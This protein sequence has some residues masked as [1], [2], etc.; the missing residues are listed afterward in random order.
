MFYRKKDR[1]SIRKFKVGV[2]SVFLG[3]FLL[4]TPQ[5]YADDAV[6][7][8]AETEVVSSTMEDTDKPVA[9]ESPVLSKDS[10][11]VFLTPAM[12]DD[13]IVKVAEVSS[14]DGATTDVVAS[15]SEESVS[16][17]ASVSTVTS[18]KKTETRP[19]GSST[20]VKSEVP[21][22][23]SSTE[24]QNKEEVNGLSVSQV[25]PDSSV[26]DSDTKEQASPEVSAPKDMLTVARTQTPEEITASA[27]PSSELKASYDRLNEATDAAALELM[28]KKARRAQ[29]RSTTFPNEGKAI[30]TGAGFRADVAASLLTEPS[31]I[32]RPANTVLDKDGFDVLKRFSNKPGIVYV[33]NAGTRTT[34]DKNITEKQKSVTI[35]EVDTNTGKMTPVSTSVLDDGTQVLDHIAK[36]RDEQKIKPGDN[37]NP[38]YVQMNGLGLSQDGRYAY[39]FGFTSNINEEDRTT[40]NGIYRY[41][42]QSK[43]WSLVSNASNWDANFA[44]LKTNSWTAGA[45]NPA[46]GKY[47]FGTYTRQYDP[48]F[49]TVQF[50]N[51]NDFTSKVTTVRDAISKD[52]SLTDEQKRDM[53]AESIKKGGFEFYFRLFSYD[54]V[55]HKV[56]DVGYTSTHIVETGSFDWTQTYWSSLALGNDIVF[57]AEGN[58]KIT[59]NQ[60]GK[61]EFQVL[62]ISKDEIAKGVAANNK[63]TNLNSTLSKKIAITLADGNALPADAWAMG[64]AALDNNGNFYL[65]DSLNVIKSYSDFSGTTL[66]FTRKDDDKSLS[67]WGDAASIFGSVGTGSVRREYYIENT[68]TILEGQVGTIVNGKFVSQDK[69]TTGKENIAEKLEYYKVY[70]S[71]N[72]PQ[73]IQAKNGDVYILVKNQEGNATLKYGSDLETGQVTKDEQVIKYQYKKLTGDVILHYVDTDGHVLQPNHHLKDDVPVG[74]KYEVTKGT[75]DYPNTIEKDDIVYK[76]KEISADGIVNKVKVATENVTLEQTGDV[77]AGKKNIVY[78]YEPTGSVVIHYVNTKGE[79][80]KKEVQDNV[81]NATIGTAYNAT[82]NGEK[83]E[84]ITHGGKTYKIKETN[85]TG[86]VGT[87]AIVTPN[88]TNF[89]GEEMSTIQTPGKTHVIYVYEEVPTEPSTPDKQAA[90]I[91]YYD[92]TTGEKVQL[93][94]VDKE[95]GV[96]GGKA[97]YTTTKRIKEYED[98]GYELVND[99]VPIPIIFDNEKDASEADPTQK[100][101]VLLSHA[102]V[103]VDPAS[104]KDPNEPI[105]PKDPS[106]PKWP[107][108]EEAQVKRTATRTIRYRYADKPGLDQEAVFEDVV[109]TVEFKRAANV[110]KVT[111]KVVSYG[112]WEAVVAEIPEKASPTKEGYIF[113]KDAPKETATISEDGTISGIHDQLILYKKN[114]VKTGSVVVKYEDTEGHKIAEDE[115]DTPE[116]PVGTKY[117]TYDQIEEII[118][119]DD[120]DVY[121]LKELKKGSANE[122]GEVVEGVT[123]VTYVYE[124]AGF[125]EVKYVDETGTEIKATVGAVKYAKPGSNY[126]TTT[127]TLRPTK[128]TTQD[129]KVYELVSEG[130]YTVGS[131]DSVGH[132]TSTD[133]VDG[134]VEAGKTKS[135]TY[136]YKEVKNDVPTPPKAANTGSVVVHYVNTEGEVIH[137]D[138]KDT[139]DAPVGTE[140]NAAET[141]LEKPDYIRF[142]GKTYKYK[143]FTNSNHVNNKVIVP[144]SDYDFIGPEKSTVSSGTTHVIYV[145]EEVKED[146]PTIPEPIKT[147]AV[148]VRYV[149][150]NGE[151]IKD[152]VF[153]EKNQPEGIAYDTTDDNRPT[154]VLGKDGQIYEIVGAGEQNVGMV[155]HHGRLTAPAGGQFWKPSDPETGLVE[156]D[157]IKEITY[158]YKLKEVPKA[159]IKKGSVIVRYEDTEGNEINTPAQDTIDAP[160]GTPY[161]TFDNRLEVIHSDNTA[162][163]A[164][165]V[166]YLKEVKSNSASETGIVTEGTTTVT[167]V[168]EKGG[169]V[170]VNY[171]DEN[172][173]EIQQTKRVLSDAKPGSYYNVTTTNIRP[174]QI[175]TEDGKIYE[176]V[177]AGEYAVGK[178]DSIG[179]LTTT[180]AVESH[181]EANKLKSVTYVYKLKESTITPPAEAP[182]TGTVLVHYVNTNGDEIH[183]KYY[184]T[185]NAPIGTEYNTA[186]S[187]VEK[188]KFINFE[189]KTYKYKGTEETTNIINGKVIVPNTLQDYIRSEKSTVLSGTV[190]VIYVYEEVKE[191]VPPTPDTKLGSVVVRYVDENGKE[192]KDEVPDTMDAPEGTRYETYDKKENIITTKEGDVY[193]FKTVDEQSAPEAGNVKEGTTTVTYVYEKAGNVVVNYKDKEGNAIQDPVKDEE[194]SKPGTPYD[195]MDNRPEEIK[196]KDGKTYKRVP[197]LTEGEETGKVVSG[198]TEVTYVYEEVKGK[199]VVHYI[200]L[201]GKTIKDDVVDTPETSTGV[202]YDTKDHKPATITKDG[203]EYELLPALTQGQETGKVVSGTTEVTYVYRLK[204]I[205]PTVTPAN[206]VGSVVIQYVNTKGETIAT[207]VKDT[208]NA[209]VDTDYDTTDY[210]PEKIYKDGKVYHYREVKEDSAAETGKVQEGTLT[211]TYVYE[212]YGSYIPYVPNDP[213]KPDPK[214][215]NPKYDEPKVPY[216]D[217]PKDSKDNPP[218][219]F[220]PGHTPKAPDGNPLKP[221]DPN[222]PMRG[223]I[224]PRITDP[225]DPSQDTPVPYVPNG[226]YVPHIKDPDPNKPS[227]PDK[228][229]Y[230]DTP[231]D[232]KDNPPLPYVPGYEPK[233][234]ADPTGETPLK[235]VDPKDPM[236]GYIPPTITDPN[237]PTKDTPVPYKPVGTVV[238]RYEDT[239]GHRIADQVIDTPTSKVDTSYDTRDHK[240]VEITFNGDKYILVPRLTKGAEEG[241]VVKGETVITYVYQKVANWIPEIPEVPRENRPKIPYPFDPENPDSPIDPTKPNDP[242]KPDQPPVIP[243]VP[244]YIPVN[245]KDPHQPLKPAP[246]DPNSPDGYIPPVPDKPGNDIYIPYVPAGTVTIHYVDEMGNSVQEDRVDT[247]KSPVGTSYNAAENEMEKPKEITKDGKVYEFVKVKEDSAPVVGQIKQGNMDVTYVYRLKTNPPVETPGQYIPY[248]PVDPTNPTA[249]NDPMTPPVNPE[250]GKEIPPLPY[251]ETPEDPSDDPRLPD[252]PD[253]IP[254]DPTDPSKPLPKDPNGCYI[255][256]TPTNPKVNTPIPYLPAGTVIVK[257]KDTKGGDIKDPIVDTEKSL[258]GTSYDTTDHQNPSNE[259][260]KPAEII[261]QG[262]RYILVPSLTQGQE[263]GMVSKGETV[264][265]YVYQKVANWIPV[266]PNV[267]EKDRPSLPYPFDPT[268]P[269]DPVDPKKPALPPIPHVPGYTPHDPDGNPLKPV[270]PNDPTKGYIPPVPKEL[271]KD[272]YIPYVPNDSGRPTPPAQEMPSKPVPDKP[273]EPS[274][275]V[276]D[277]PKESA[278][279]M[280]PVKSAKRTKEMTPSYMKSEAKRLPNT[281]EANQGGVVYG[282]AALS[283]TALLA[284]MKKKFDNEE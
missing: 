16:Q 272:T 23:A 45:I 142:G 174:T 56:S 262:E 196:T 3:S 116:S 268:H 219:P 112:Q 169:S 84:T 282:A 19:T 110:D 228:V 184:D 229:P 26:T 57:D 163:N 225:N 158:V 190:H 221:K 136:V 239:E 121:Y 185:I 223:Y 87:T 234:P 273:K 97:A 181:I 230:D 40:L 149:D 143:E 170:V 176:L 168:Y 9:P 160:V 134:R 162:T 270:D 248:I 21:S 156:G 245:P 192:I 275:P 72:V 104:P 113:D 55:T 271:E 240:P 102:I 252:V 238:V 77:I 146:V 153:D 210:K 115:V 88:A 265:T 18:P 6:E 96:V 138:Y 124:K 189:G 99:G 41:D 37:G 150:I 280:T 33:Q 154:T 85:T 63:Y 111:G 274:K 30:P 114:D 148:L 214:D 90:T 108:I 166:Y 161:E 89:I 182:K 183:A 60:F 122:S 171:V 193:Y 269:N 2:G 173:K 244:D 105:N 139:T 76:A 197:E 75:S 10:S 133:N 151:S 22:N 260:T 199:V 42:M 120:K 211:V 235:P 62:D 20:T 98:K 264:V 202:D 279:P 218:L 209:K 180:D 200:D 59:L 140:Y 7:M 241:K 207:D 31:T 141:Q 82:E 92:V 34:N 250:T 130:S 119:K 103:P 204:E 15:T 17:N 195:T 127:T 205:P 263:K 177:P 253:Y 188:P 191:E 152:P 215:P 91:T 164:T 255:P 259:L 78:V 145:Y 38:A 132:L 194:N 69:A 46:D 267:P 86:T 227:D 28:A 12:S 29:Q 256:P 172:G 49:S 247:L 4:G 266:I 216:D 1:F 83:P 43:K 208:V 118:T 178:V 126:D 167:Y 54:P 254:V 74:E 128:I 281:G 249:P 284:A 125:V 80:I 24:I 66:P 52:A 222:N 68:D 44:R 58:A 53:M 25:T 61:K 64:G 131:V 47:Y 100:Y 243:D 94:S 27:L 165:D 236:K 39:A 101:E 144:R 226:N 220:I 201:E 261:H 8:K 187:D 203:H 276:P 179:H 283:L 212:E 48:N 13:T 73:A 257:Y 70:E 147:G 123:T 224:P 232:P 107:V 206:K 79:I 217:T 14:V 106:S 67:A 93:G 246:K 50:G 32:V 186:E 278:K 251:D 65:T 137:A 129:G 135:I 175:T 81:T 5:V 117:E 109:Q 157:K 213:K 198:T 258:V 277:K 237:D 155:D 242:T 36:L 95:S 51:T 11:E 71:L 35:Y 233:D 159:E 231:N